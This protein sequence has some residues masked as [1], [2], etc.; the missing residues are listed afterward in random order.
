MG[1]I[2]AEVCSL[3]RYGRAG[4]RPRLVRGLDDDRPLLEG[5]VR[6]V[7][8]PSVRGIMTPKR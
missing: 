5:G 3:E 4:G 6:G 2:A 8:R 7:V 1:C